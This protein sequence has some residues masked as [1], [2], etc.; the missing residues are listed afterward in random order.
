M[1]R[2]ILFVTLLAGLLYS[3]ACGEYSF[4]VV[5]MD[6]GTTDYALR[7]Q[8]NSVTVSLTGAVVDTFNLE[9]DFKTLQ[10]KFEYSTTKSSGDV[11]I[12]IEGIDL[13]GATIA[14]GTGTASLKAGDSGTATVTMAP[15][16]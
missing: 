2:A 14:R 1:R 12:V 15:S 13:A 7:Q 11:S 10:G 8:V 9:K 3:S 5:T 6:P 16:P 4:I